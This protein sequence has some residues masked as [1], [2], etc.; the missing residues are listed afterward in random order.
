LDEAVAFA[1][2]RE[3]RML[4]ATILVWG[5]PANPVE[6]WSTYLYH[7]TEDFR[8]ENPESTSVRLAYQSGDRSDSEVAWLLIE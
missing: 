7:F 6:L 4:I 8:R 3:L 2:P 5:S 1:M